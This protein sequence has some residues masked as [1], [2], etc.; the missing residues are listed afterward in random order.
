MGTAL[1]PEFTVGRRTVRD[2]APFRLRV[3]DILLPANVP[4]GCN[5]F[6]LMSLEIGRAHV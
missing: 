3:D 2:L 4:A 5:P 6:V 1:E